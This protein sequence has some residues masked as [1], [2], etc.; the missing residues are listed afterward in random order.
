MRSFR[1][2]FDVAKT[3]LTSEIEEKDF[4]EESVGVRRRPYRVPVLCVRGL[5]SVCTSN[6]RIVLILLPSVP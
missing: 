3:K 2:V 6:S 5:P 1:Q 4:R